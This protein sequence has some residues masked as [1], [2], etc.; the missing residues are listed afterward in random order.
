M[1]VQCHY[2]VGETDHHDDRDQQVKA[3]EGTFL[4]SGLSYLLLNFVCKTIQ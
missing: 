1:D 2:A 3:M 4:L